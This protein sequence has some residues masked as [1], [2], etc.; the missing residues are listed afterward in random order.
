MI[1]SRVTVVG[2]GGIGGHL[3][4]PLCHFLH[5]E[6]HAAH[7]T[8]VDGDAYEA[9]NASRMR[10]R[11]FE[12]KAVAM[13]RELASAFGDVLTIAPRPEYVTPANVASLASPGDLIFLAVDNH[14][15]RQLVDAHCA[16]LDDVILISGGNDG[17][18]GGEAG[19]F[20]NVQVVRRAGGRALSNTLSAF[21]PEIADPADR[22]PGEASCGELVVAG[23]PQLL[24]TNL[25]VASAM[26]NAFW[27]VVRGAPA[28]EE[29]YLDIAK[30]RVEPV[31]RALVARG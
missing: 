20:G 15:T 22:A 27:A 5:A 18:E 25:A 13:A 31:E 12:N 14:R 4:P 19:T 2:C 28:Y 8:L 10:F 29:V 16:T 1:P 3:A 6:R 9:R 30:N 21:H 23:A 7:V 26:L 17:I 24:F 11:R